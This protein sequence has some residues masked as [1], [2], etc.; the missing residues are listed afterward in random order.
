MKFF[1]AL[2]TVFLISSQAVAAGE[3]N[4]YD[5]ASQIDHNSKNADWSGFYLGLQ[6]SSDS[7]TQFRFRPG[8]TESS[9]MNRLEGGMQSGFVGYNLQRGPWVFGGEIA[10]LSGDT[11]YVPLFSL[12]RFTRFTDYKARLG[13][14]FGNTL[15]YG[16]AGYSTGAWYGGF[17]G[18]PGLPWDGANYG[19]GIQIKADNGL[20][21]GL[22]YL[23]R[24]G[25]IEYSFATIET[26]VYSMQLR[27]GWQ[28]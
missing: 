6:A 20:F 15:V 13:Y 19:G 10:S 23:V 2:T 3:I 14:S 28:F 25:P 17:V 21:F 22:E 1:C 5:Q 7:G 24:Q 4:T 26:S 9:S 12:Y 27:A 18:G 8:E 16:V 11:H